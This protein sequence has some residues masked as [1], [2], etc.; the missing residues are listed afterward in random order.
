MADDNNKPSE[1]KP[2]NSSDTELPKIDP[3]LISYEEKK[4]SEGEKEKRSE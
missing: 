4:L 2:D 3:S 1:V